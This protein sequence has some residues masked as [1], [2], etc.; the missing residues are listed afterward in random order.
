[1]FKELQD[2]TLN[3]DSVFTVKVGSNGKETVAGW[4]LKEPEDVI[5]ALRFL[6]G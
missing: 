2:S 6:D 5:A 4:H 1:M 3:G